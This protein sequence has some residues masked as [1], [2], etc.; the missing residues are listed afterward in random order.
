MVGDARAA[1]ALVETINTLL[2]DKVDI[3]IQQLKVQAYNTGGTMP[4][5]SYLSS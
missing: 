2:G 3:D 5:L 4:C 1:L